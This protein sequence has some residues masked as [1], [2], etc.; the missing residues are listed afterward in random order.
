MTKTIRY[1]NSEIMTMAA[2]LTYSIADQA[3]STE[4]ELFN[5][6]SLVVWS[7]QSDNTIYQDA[8]V[9]HAFRAIHD[10]VHIETG[11]GFSPQDE[12]EMGRIQAAKLASQCKSLLADLFYCEIAEQASY[13]EKNGVFI[14]NQVEFTQKYINLGVSK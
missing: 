14:P 3:P 5:S 10:A 1:I 13:Y 8:T 11:L 2:K 12:I 6:T 9:N 7:G 4:L